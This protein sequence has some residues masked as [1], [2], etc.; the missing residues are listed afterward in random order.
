[1]GGNHSLVAG[2]AINANG[3]IIDPATGKTLPSDV[4]FKAS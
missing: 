1:M 2:I 3:N 4:R